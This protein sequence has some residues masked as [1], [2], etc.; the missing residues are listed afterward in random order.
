[1]KEQYV[2]RLSPSKFEASKGCPCFKEDQGYGKQYK[3]RGTDLHKLVEDESLPLDGLD[4]EARDAVLYCRAYAADM[5]ANFD[6][7]FEARELSID[8][9]DVHPR[10]KLDFVLLARYRVL[11]I[12]DW[13]FGEVEVAAEDNPQMEAYALMAYNHLS[14]LGYAIARIE[15]GPVQ[16]ALLA[17]PT[18]IIEIA[19]LPRIEADL[20]KANDRVTDPV[21]LPDASDPDK[22]KRCEYLSRCPAI[23]R[24]IVKMTTTFGLPMPEAFDPGAL[25]SVKDRVIAQDL[26]VILEAWSKQVRAKNKEYAIENGGTLGDIWNVTTRSNGTEIQDLRGFADALVA[27][28]V[29]ENPDQL[30]DFV[31]LQ[32]EKL[33]QGLSGPGRDVAPLVAALE[34]RLGVPRPPV[35]VF[36]RGG[37][38]QVKAAE[39]ALGVPMLENPFRATGE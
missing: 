5:R 23:T 2:W 30:L 26:A 31:K 9:T 3:D 38:K 32:K 12:R 18:A 21:K 20:K 4:D 35:S 28:G 10:G 6:P 39:L 1:M 24:G 27:E 7:V 33:V 37:K 17:A 36:K 29:L 16:P 19:D 25:V 13:K 15:V 11:H 8:A 14:A 34:E 22:C